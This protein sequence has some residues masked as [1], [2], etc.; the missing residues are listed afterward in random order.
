LQSLSQGR[1]CLGLGSSTEPIVERW[2]G[3]ALERPLTR[4]RE[5]VEV[6]RLALLGERVAFDGQTVQVRDFRLQLGPTEVPIVLA[7]LGPRML[8][9]AGEIA[10]GVVLSFAGLSAIPTQLAAVGP[11]HARP[12]FDVLQRIGVA[13]DEDPDR[14]RSAV[15]RELAI[16]GAARAYNAAFARQGYAAE[17]EA[18]QAAWQRADSRAAAEA[19]SERLIAD[20]YV[21]GSPEAC[22]ARLAAYREAGLRTPIVVPIALDA[23]PAERRRRRLRVLESLV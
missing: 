9:L 11:A 13:V 3:L 20:T 10:D 17:A 18:M 1:F 16:Y 2:M 21:F 22:R 5:T 23:D 14:F 7:A 4:V 6:I 15:R 12:D 8:G 19:V